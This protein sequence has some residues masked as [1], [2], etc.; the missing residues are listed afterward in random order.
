MPDFRYVLWDAS[1]YSDEE[2]KGK[3]T[4]RVALLL[5]KYMGLVLTSA[6]ML[7][8]ALFVFE[9]SRYV[10]PLYRFSDK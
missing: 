1:R 10:I 4:L 7:G 8:F 3:A 2:I 9:E 6:I 5:M